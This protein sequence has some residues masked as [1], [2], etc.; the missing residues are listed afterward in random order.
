MS[1]QD[2]GLPPDSVR[3]HRQEGKGFGDL[4]ALPHPVVAGV[5]VVNGVSA[6]LGALHMAGRVGHMLKPGDKAPDFTLADQDESSVSL[7]A[8]RGHKTFVYL[9]P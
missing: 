3:S 5:A 6:G 1:G 4:V 7:S 2:P 8:P 9:Y